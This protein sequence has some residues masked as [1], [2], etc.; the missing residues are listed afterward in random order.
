[1]LAVRTKE[2]PACIDAMPRIEL[3]KYNGLATVPDDA[4]CAMPTIE[5]CNW[6]D[7]CAVT[8]AMPFIDD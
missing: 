6:V 2:T 8:V 1:M 4:N 5:D 3:F 7:V